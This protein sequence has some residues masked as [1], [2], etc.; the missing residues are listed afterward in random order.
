MKV[1]VA[2][3]GIFCI[4]YLL[5][6]CGCQR[7]QSHKIVFSSSDNKFI[8]DVYGEK[9]NKIDPW[10]VNLVFHKNA[11]S[12]TLGIEVFSGEINK[13]TVQCVW[14]T[15]STCLLIFDQQDDTRRTFEVEKNPLSIKEINYG[16]SDTAH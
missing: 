14:K 15:D 6:I 5:I 13:E 10:M 11:K 2:W 8:I 16:Q 9:P 12:D 3:G 1:A 7:K 4:L